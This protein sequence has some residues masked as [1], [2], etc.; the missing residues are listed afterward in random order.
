MDNIGREHKLHLYPT[1]T[2]VHTHRQY[3]SS[4]NNSNSDVMIIVYVTIS[5][6]VE[7]CLRISMCIFIL[8]KEIAPIL[9][10]SR[11]LYTNS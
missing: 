9:Y 7:Y 10:F 11:P 3:R 4:Y 6:T 1:K 5:D 2:K 8:K